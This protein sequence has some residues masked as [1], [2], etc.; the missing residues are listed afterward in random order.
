MP[1]S[2]ILV[3]ALV[4]APSL[5]TAHSPQTAS[6]IEPQ[7]KRAFPILLEAPGGGSTHTLAGTAIRTKTFF[8]VQ[9]YA[10]GLYV[11]AE[12]A[13]RTLRRWRDRSAR[14]LGRDEAFYAEL[15]ED[16]FGKTLRLVM[17]RDVG[18]D[19]MGEAFTD[20]LAPRVQRYDREHNTSGGMGAVSEF[21]TYFDSE[22]LAKETVLVVSWE[23]GGTLI[24]TVAGSVRGEINSPALCW[25]LFDVYLGEDPV[26]K[27]GKRT[28]IER[29][30]EVL[31]SV[32][33]QHSRTDLLGS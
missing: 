6:I 29:M 7:S 16:N 9:V 20:A 23:P 32:G 11:D 1:G 8:N 25:A 4:L 22:E 15:L 31:G 14:D 30:P 27:K 17:T 28:V 10:Y 24:T 21:R 13:R 2:K 5:A 12:A 18:G 3:A 19:D 26:M 33:G